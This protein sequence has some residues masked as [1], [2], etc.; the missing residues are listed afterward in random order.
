MQLALTNQK[1]LNERNIEILIGMD[2]NFLTSIYQ[3]GKRVWNAQTQNIISTNDWTTFVISWNSGVLALYE[4]G[5]Q[6]PFAI[7]IINEPFP[8]NF[9]GIATGE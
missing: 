3:D 9:I 4:A 7:H 8:I 5:H 2:R 1:T 6:L